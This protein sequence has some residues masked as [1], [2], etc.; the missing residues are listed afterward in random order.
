M[1]NTSQ[2]PNTAR[3][4]SGDG[5][6]ENTGPKADDRKEVGLVAAAVVVLALG[7]AGFWA[8]RDTEDSGPK[9]N[10]VSSLPHGQ[11]WQ[12]SKEPSIEVIHQAIMPVGALP[13]S[14]IDDM[15]PAMAPIDRVKVDIY[16]GFDQSGLT[17]EA[18][19]ILREQVESISPASGWTATVHGHTDGIGSAEYNNSL[20]L[21]RAK[22][23][24]QFLLSQG[25]SDTAISIAG[26]GKEGAVCLETTKA[27]RQQNRRVN[28]ELKKGD[29]EM[30]ST[31]TD[32][33]PDGGNPKETITMATA[34]QNANKV[35]SVADVTD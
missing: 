16:F 23:V 33:I 25:L 13:V 31:S 29:A 10:Q 5:S 28:V 15:T 34:D 26:R 30:V 19:T 35:A 21:K 18:K 17:E 32:V 12:E 8:F 24:R 22:S 27:C 1:S 9:T 20:G 11:G 2:K 4:A 6:R 3:E 7:G 14:T